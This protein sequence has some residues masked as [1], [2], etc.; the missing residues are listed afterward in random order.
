MTTRDKNPQ[1]KSLLRKAEKIE[2]KWDMEGKYTAD[3]GQ[4]ANARKRGWKLHQTFYAK[5]VV[6]TDQS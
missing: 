5:V 4:E 6:Q 2:R 3:R 1:Y